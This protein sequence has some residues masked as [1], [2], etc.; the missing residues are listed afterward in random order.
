MVSDC[1]DVTVL[2]IVLFSQLPLDL[3]VP[4]VLVVQSG[5]VRLLGHCHSLKYHAPC[6]N[7]TTTSGHALSTLYR[8]AAAALAKG[9][10]SPT[11]DGR[12]VVAAQQPTVLAIR[13]VNGRVFGAF[14]THCWRREKRATGT[15]A[16][17]EIGLLVTHAYDTP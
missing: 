7:T 13:T 14:A 12:G 10:G 16:A 15:L 9:G 17:S 3:S 11:K 4:V 8:K 2:L 6:C 5:V 1:D